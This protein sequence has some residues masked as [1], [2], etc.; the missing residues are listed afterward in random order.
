MLYK[1]DKENL[2]FKKTYKL[3][4]Y[5]LISLC[6]LLF[7]A[8]TL[9][10]AIQLST[11]KE[12]LQKV[13]RQ[14]DRRIATIIQP[15]R[16]ESYVEDLYKNI[17]FT[18]TEEQYKKFEYL[19]LKYRDKIE[20][21][22]VPATLV[23]WVAY[24]ESRFNVKADNSTSTAK[25]TFQFLDGTWNAMCKLKGINTGG[26]FNEEKQVDILLTYLN[27]FY[28]REKNWGEVMHHYHGGEYQ[29]PIKF[30]FK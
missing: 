11:E 20:E 17:G 30:L 10:S 19:S 22:K 28:H 2:I 18:L 9:I 8:G 6:L 23:W 29:Y 14:K 15:L 7:F 16:V 27:Y 12:G 5:K 4:K 24:K 21:A 13:I 26:R 1:Y 3:L 25:G